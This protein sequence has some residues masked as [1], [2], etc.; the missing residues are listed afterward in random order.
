MAPPRI[1]PAAIV[2]RFDPIAHDAAD[3]PGHRIGN[4]GAAPQQQIQMGF[5]EL[6]D[7]LVE[8]SSMTNA[9][10]QYAG[11]VHDLDDGRYEP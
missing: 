1:V 8:E 6:R 10:E 9:H 3:Q 5:G 4:G 7:A 11:R 2:H